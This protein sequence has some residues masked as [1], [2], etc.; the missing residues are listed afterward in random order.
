MMDSMPSLQSFS[1]STPHPLLNSD[2]RQLQFCPQ[3]KV[4]KIIA[5]TLWTRTVRANKSIG[6]ISKETC[7]GMGCTYISLHF[8]TLSDFFLLWRAF[9][10]G[11]VIGEILGAD[12]RL[13][14]CL[15]LKRWSFL[16]DKEATSLCSCRNKEFPALVIHLSLKAREG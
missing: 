10:S 1:F 16:Q 8:W 5:A 2:S 9:P 7:L 13:V 11:T 3:P 14:L 6:L 4:Q 15:S 12:L